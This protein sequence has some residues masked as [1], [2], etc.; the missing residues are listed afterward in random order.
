MVDWILY[1]LRCTTNSKD[2]HYL[3][4]TL[5]LSPHFLQKQDYQ[6]FAMFV[7]STVDTRVR[8][9]M[10]PLFISSMLPVGDGQEDCTLF[11]Y[12]MYTKGNPTTLF[13]FLPLSFSFIA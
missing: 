7:F 10:P 5:C 8:E 13:S 3:Y 6:S 12:I 4:A 1:L 2:G 9:Q 11:T